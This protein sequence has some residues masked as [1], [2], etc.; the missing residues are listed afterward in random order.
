MRI[1]SLLARF[2]LL[3][4]LCLGFASAQ[5]T[6]TATIV[7]TVTDS[8]GAVVPGAKVTARNVERSFVYEGVTNETGAYYIP[9]LTSGSYQLTVEASGFKTY[10]RGGVVLRINEQPRIDI[11]L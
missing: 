7:G 9:N 3:P 6:G 5:T 2:V 10:Q 1:D 4:L 8:T 11:A